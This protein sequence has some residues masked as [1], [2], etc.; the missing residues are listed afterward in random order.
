[1]EART[2][3]LLSSVCVTPFS[4]GRRANKWRA[5]WDSEI[6]FAVAGYALMKTYPRIFELTLLFAVGVCQTTAQ[7]TQLP[8]QPDVVGDVASGSASVL[9]SASAAEGTQPFDSE[10]APIVKGA[11]SSSSRLDPTTLK[12]SPDPVYSLPNASENLHRFLQQSCSPFSFLTIG[13]NTGL[14]QIGKQE[15]DFGFGIHGFIRRYSTSL[16]DNRSNAFFGAFLLPSLLHQEQR[17]SRLGPKFSPW[18]RATYSLSRVAITRGR[19]G[20]DVFNSSL[21]LATLFSKSLQNAY[22]P[23]DQRG[24]AQTMDRT[25]RTLLDRAQNNLAQEFLPD[26]E[27]F[28]WRHMPKRLKQ[29]ERHMP[30]SSQWEP[31]AFSEKDSDVR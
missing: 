19:D 29:I 16:A 1:M 2:G 18:R 8:Q 6:Q 9:A 30:F 26:V 4:N 3:W 14:A 20:G 28:C 22:Y 12:A 27:R 21:I 24:F 7:T 15:P 11:T 10:D 31:P 23:S 17:Y 25:E 13:F 5:R